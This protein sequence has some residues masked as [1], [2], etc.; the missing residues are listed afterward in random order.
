M[1]IVPL[2]AANW[3]DFAE[4]MSSDDQCSQCWCLNHRE[5][6]GCVTGAAARDRMKILTEANRVGGLLAYFGGQCCGWVAIDPMTVLVG[7]D[8]QPTAVPG[9]W[10]IH[11]L[12]VKEAFRGQGVSSQLILA[13]IDFG[14]SQGAVV[15]SAFPIPK[16][17][18]HRFPKHEAEF[19]GRMSSFVKLGFKAVGQPTDFYQRVELTQLRTSNC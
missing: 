3:S 10:S 5:R 8:C 1:K 2:T 4:L 19:S 7:H 18:R 9:E 17:N 16:E 14:R 13:A 6:P 12:F 11:C 15:I